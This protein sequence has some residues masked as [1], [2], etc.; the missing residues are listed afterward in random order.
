[1]ADEESA[2]TISKAQANLGDGLANLATGLGTSKDKAT[3]NQWSHSGKNYDHVTLSARFREDWIS[4]KVVKV[5]PQDM[6]REW[7]EFESDS[8]TEADEDF[9][10]LFEYGIDNFGVNKAK[11]YSS[12]MKKILE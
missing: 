6:T 11:S 10:R 2:I 4:Q 9:E 8:A 1:M 12:G 7:R 5:I 3:H